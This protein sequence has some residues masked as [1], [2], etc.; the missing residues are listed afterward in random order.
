MIKKD[1]NILT[2][3]DTGK[4]KTGSTAK[5]KI[6]KKYNSYFNGLKYTGYAVKTLLIRENIEQYNPQFLQDAKD[7][8]R[9]FQKLESLDHERFYTLALDGAKRLI[10]VN[11]TFQGTLNQS[12][13]HPREVFKIA[14]L[15][16]AAGIVVIHNHP[17]G[18]CEPSREDFV[19]TQRLA[20]AGRIMGIE[21]LDHIIIGYEG[22]YSFQKK[23][24]LKSF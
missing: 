7:V 21:L 22:F 19:V 3:F 16:S 15:C 6:K 17:S 18:K 2:V 8:Y 11:L 20:D 5:T 12:L 4:N 23:G 10:A 9:M 24:T 13:V 1:K 14:L